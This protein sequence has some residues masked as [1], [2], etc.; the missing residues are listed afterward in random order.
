MKLMAEKHE[1]E[2]QMIC[3]PDD[4]YI[5][6][7]YEHTHAHIDIIC[8]TLIPAWNSSAWKKNSETKGSHWPALKEQ[9]E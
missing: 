1:L 6:L 4:M 9:E 5:S 7:F 2:W 8:K 3:W